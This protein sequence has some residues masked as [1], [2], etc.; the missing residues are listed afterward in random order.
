MTKDLASRFHLFIPGLVFIGHG[1]QARSNKGLA[2]QKV[3]YG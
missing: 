2:L 3:L 1:A